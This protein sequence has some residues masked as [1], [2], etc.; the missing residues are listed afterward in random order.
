MAGEDREPSP[1]IAAPPV[2]D[3]IPPRLRRTGTTSRGV[4]AMCA[5]GTLM[6]ALF[7]SRDLP[8]WSERLADAPGGPAMQRLAADWDEAMARLG[9][10]RPHEA[11]RAAVQRALGWQWSSDSR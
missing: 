8:S 1:A 5:I 10:V 4:L 6:L 7:A 9:L 3:A 11:L 2:S